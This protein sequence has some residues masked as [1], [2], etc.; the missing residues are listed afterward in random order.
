MVRKAAG[1]GADPVANH[2]APRHLRPAVAIC[3]S[4]RVPG[5]TGRLAGAAR[6]GA[7]RGP[8]GRF[9]RNALG[10]DGGLALPSPRMLHVAAAVWT[11]PDLPVQVLC[12]CLG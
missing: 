1:G 10:H 3:T 2:K 6:R 7:T 12:A 5:R 9:P 8:G 11:L 4:A